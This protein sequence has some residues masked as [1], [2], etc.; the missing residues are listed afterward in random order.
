VAPSSQLEQTF[1]V[2]LTDISRLAR[3]EFDRRVRDLGLTRS[4]WLFLYHIGRT[5]GMTQTELADRLQ[6]EKISVSRQA[7][8]LLR[9][10]WIERRPHAHDG[11]AYNLYTA[12]KARRI[13]ARLTAAASE[14]RE[15]YFHGLSAS[16]RSALMDDLRHIKTNLLRLEAEAH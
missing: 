7:E 13:V 1:G 2:L 4:Q 12:P 10:G 3:K 9:A 15:E 16:R 8:R 11:R 5:P 14:L 6:V